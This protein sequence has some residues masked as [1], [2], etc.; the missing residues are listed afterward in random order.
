MGVKANVNNT[1]RKAELITFRCKFLETD[2]ERKK[3]YSIEW[4]LLAQDMN[5]QQVLM[6][7][8]FP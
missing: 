3:N 2:L 5:Q 4:I 6:Y 7:I 8:R 1:D